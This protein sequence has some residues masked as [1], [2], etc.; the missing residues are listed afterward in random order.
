VGSMEAGE[1]Q[2]RCGRKRCGDDSGHRTT[3]RG[4]VSG[5][6]PGGITGR[7]ISP[8]PGEAAVH[9]ESRREAAAVGDP[10]GAG[11]G[12]ANGGEVA[13]GADLRG[14]FHE[15]SYGFRPKRSA[16]QALEAIRVAGNRGHNL[17]VDADIQGYFDMYRT[18]F[19]G[20]FS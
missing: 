5:G 19:P 4:G 11:P 15:C 2:P 16:Q 1:Q 3:R 17:V 20:R 18:R 7:P 13:G 10:D 12:D 6:D 14:G 9:T 8:F